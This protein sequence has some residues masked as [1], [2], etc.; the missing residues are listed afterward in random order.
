V[1]AELGRATVLE[2]RGRRAEAVDAL[3]ELTE[4][5]PLPA[6]V[7]LLADLHRL[8]GRTEEAG[9][10][11]EVAR[12]A[13]GS[14]S[15]AGGVVDL[16]RALFEADRG[17]PALAVSLATAAHDARHT[18]FT[19]DALAWSLTRAGRAAEAVP[20]AEAALRLGT[21][22]ATLRF[23]AATTFASAGL[24]DRA[25]AELL[26]AAG[27]GGPL[28][29]LHRAAGVELAGRLGVVAPD[30]WRVG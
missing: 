1:L 16:E 5:F 28:P 2:L 30:L 17:D 27:A 8:E 7:A 20:H 18:I 21:R 23:H 3:S 15:S 12:A 6:A 11:V 25:R 13:F 19:A 9:I 29:P 26:A 14:V 22:D 4:R 24:L 10:E